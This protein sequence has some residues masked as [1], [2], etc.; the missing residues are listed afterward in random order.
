MHFHL[1]VTHFR[2][3]VLKCSFEHRQ[4]ILALPVVSCLCNIVLFDSL[5]M[6]L[7]LAG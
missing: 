5:S 2:K 1:S 4:E 7:I 6:V 3:C